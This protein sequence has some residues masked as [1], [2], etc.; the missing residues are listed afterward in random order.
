MWS[1]EIRNNLSKEL[2][3]QLDNKKFFCVNDYHDNATDDIKTKNQ[4]LSKSNLAYAKTFPLSEA[5][6]FTNTIK[7]ISFSNKLEDIQKTSTI[8]DLSIENRKIYK[9]SDLLSA[10][11]EETVVIPYNA[12]STSLALIKKFE[13]KDV[14]FSDVST[15]WS[16]IKNKFN[17]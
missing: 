11:L 5:Y 15:A 6:D 12:K 1:E 14:L 16:M 10:N 9:I 17:W 13:W 7:G 2:E 8:D 4:V 3:I